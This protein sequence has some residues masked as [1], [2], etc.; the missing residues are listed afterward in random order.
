VRGEFVDVGG[1]RLYYYAA[2]T[3]GA[4]APVL[5]LHGFAT[6]AHEWRQ[7]IP[8][9][10]PGHRV[11]ALDLAGHGRSEAMRDS[12]STA[13]AHA[14]LVRGVLDELRSGIVNVVAHGFGCEVALDLA[15]EAGRVRSLLLIAPAGSEQRV[16]GIPPARSPAAL[17]LRLRWGIPATAPLRHHLRRG[18]ASSATAGRSLERHLQWF[19]V[20]SRRSALVRQLEAAARF[21]GTPLVLQ[22]PFEILTGAGDPFVSVRRVATR[23]LAPGRGTLTTLGGERH[24][25]PEEAPDT[26]ARVLG[27]LL[28]S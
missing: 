15:G 14:T 5:L 23:F 21:Q 20:R 10:P 2:G 1:V 19:K 28:A 4:G 16:P 3:R 18:Y 12:D 25:L 24:F 13:A 17:A 7:V 11:I 26:V 6:S 8:R 22:Q 27:R 9:V